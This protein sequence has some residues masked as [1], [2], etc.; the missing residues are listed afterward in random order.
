M[1]QVNVAHHRA[2]GWEAREDKS[3]PKDERISYRLGTQ[4][5]EARVR[6]GSS[7]RGEVVQQSLPCLGLIKDSFSLKTQGGTP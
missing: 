6:V 1:L 4:L 2:R 7:G 5:Q 3:G